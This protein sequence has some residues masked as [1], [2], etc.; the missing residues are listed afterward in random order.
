MNKKVAIIIPCYN[1]TNLPLTRFEKVHDLLR[2]N[3]LIDVIFV[4]DGSTDGT[5][6]FLEKTFSG[7]E[8][9]LIVHQENK[10]LSGARLTGLKNVNKNVSHII[11]KDADDDLS[12]NIDSEFKKLSPDEFGYFKKINYLN[13][14]EVT[15]WNQKDKQNLAD[16]YTTKNS[17]CLGILPVDLALKMPFEKILF[18]DVQFIKWA[19]ENTLKIK[20]K[21]IDME[22]F[23]FYEIN[24]LSRT[25][26]KEMILDKSLKCHFSWNK[27]WNKIKDEKLI[28]KRDYKFLVIKC[29][30]EIT[31]I[32]NEIHKSDVKKVVV[33]TMKLKNEKFTKRTSSLKLPFSYRIFYIFLKLRLYF[34]CSLIL[35]HKN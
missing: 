11:F 31:T 32:G 17:A 29:L 22:I 5:K 9:V 35:N 23:I 30:T 16:I 19:Y 2:I 28:S 18:E 25:S 7:V 24:S 1:I 21:K 13:G 14:K 15:S 8:N 26:N 12:S 4:N 3:K 27:L 6:D 10:G 34:L 20:T 33:E